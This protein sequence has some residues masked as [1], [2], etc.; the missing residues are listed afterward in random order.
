MTTMPACPTTMPDAQPTVREVLVEYRGRHRKPMSGL[1]RD[2][3]DAWWTKWVKQGFGE[4]YV[5]R[6]RLGDLPRHTACSSV[7]TGTDATGYTCFVCHSHLDD[8]EVSR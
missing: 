7:V 8:A 6:H 5:A 1:H 3:N 2:L 4:S